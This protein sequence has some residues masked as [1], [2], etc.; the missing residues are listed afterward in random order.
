MPSI[1]TFLH[2]WTLCTFQSD[3]GGLNSWQSDQHKVSCCSFSNVD[4]HPVPL[5]A[6]ENPQNMRRFVACLY[7]SCLSFSHS[8]CQGIP[9]FH[10]T[11][12]QSAGSPVCVWANP[13]RNV[14]LATGW[15]PALCP[16]D[17]AA[18]KRRQE[19]KNASRVYHV[20]TLCLL[21]TASSCDWAAF[22]S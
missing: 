7:A 11:T 16:V 4:G 14:N 17:L 13:H 2:S 19:G 18:T 5:T 6:S 8:H 1:Q 20:P 9:N 3:T 12:S 22:H 21:T 10:I 15:V